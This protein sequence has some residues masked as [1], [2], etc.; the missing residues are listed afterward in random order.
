MTSGV[1]LNMAVSATAGNG[2]TMSATVDLGEGELIDYNDDFA[3]D[4][5]I[6]QWTL[7]HSL[8]VGSSTSPAITLGYNGITAGVDADGVDDV[9]DDGQHDDVSIAM[10]LAGLA[11]TITMDTDAADSH[12]SLALDTQWVT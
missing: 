12:G 8:S 4:R 1:D 7:R 9:Y 3:V 2:M 5:N 10:D 6:Q 11:T